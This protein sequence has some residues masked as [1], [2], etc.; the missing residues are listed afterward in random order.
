MSHEVTPL[1]TCSSGLGTDYDYVMN[2]GAS[3]PTFADLIRTAREAKGWS[4]EQLE[5][6]TAD[7]HG[8]HVSVSTISRWERGQAGRPE[9]THVRMVCRALGLDPRK[10]AVAL[11]FL[12]REEVYGPAAGAL[13]G[14]LE[15]ILTIL[16]DPTVPDAT[17]NEWKSY[18]RYLQ[19]K[20]HRQAG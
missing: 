1:V 9:P 3:S 8:E 4:Q 2:D 14:D 5:A 20:A 19:D 15:E 11:G 12:T 16:Q 6:A 18:L 17:K 10:A 7:G 13:P